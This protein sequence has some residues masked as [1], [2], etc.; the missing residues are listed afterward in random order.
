MK[1]RIYA[2]PAVKGLRVKTLYFQAVNFQLT[3]LQ[4]LNEIRY[5]S[6]NFDLR[7]E[8]R[9]CLENTIHWANVGLL[10]GHRRRR[11]TGI[12]SATVEHLGFR[13]ADT[14]RVC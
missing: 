7:A 11:C 1:T 5:Q 6:L 12:K 4:F 2:A 14:V 13:E 9:G 3:S 10:M 8:I